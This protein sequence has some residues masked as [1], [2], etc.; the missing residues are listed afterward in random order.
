[1]TSRTPTSLQHNNNSFKYIKNNFKHTKHTF[2][3]TLQRVLENGT[4]HALSEA[5]FPAYAHTNP[6]IDWL[7]WQRL[8]IAEQFFLNSKTSGNL[9]DFGCGSGV[10]CHLMQNQAFEI[11]GLDIDLSPLNTLKAHIA[12]DEHIRWLEG[13]LTHPTLKPNTFDAITALDVLEHADDLDNALRRFKILLKPGGCL[14]VSGPTENWLYQIGR[15]LAGKEFHGE[16]HHTNIAKIKTLTA[17]H[18]QITQHKRLVAPFT[19]FEIFMA[20]KA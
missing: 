4:T 10:F 9:L 18:F 1:M 12:F 20:V 7:F 15:K 13:D 3:Q 11:T 6:L 16:Y 19:L 5:A 14:I 8:K 2:K 17:K